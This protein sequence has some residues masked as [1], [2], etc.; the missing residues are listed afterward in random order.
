MRSALCGCGSARPPGVQCLSSAAAAA[1]L[2][3][4]TMLW[5]RDSVLVRS[6]HLVA[7]Q[8][9]RL[10]V[11]LDAGVLGRR[12]LL[13]ELLRQLQQGSARQL[14]SGRSAS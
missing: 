12:P 8:L 14:S 3:T 2:T 13:V 6:P 5:C 10:A 4:C 9:V 1:W 11:L 7:E